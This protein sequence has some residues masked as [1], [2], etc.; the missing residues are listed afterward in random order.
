MEYGTVM[1]NL[2]ITR[3]YVLLVLI[4]VLLIGRIAVPALAA[5]PLRS[6]R[7]GTNKR[8]NGQFFRPKMVTG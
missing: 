1:K 4:V 7:D 3:R 5:D 6:W 2:K 8:L